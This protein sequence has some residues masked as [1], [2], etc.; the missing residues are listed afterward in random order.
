MESD[1]DA[2]DDEE[3]ILK[4]AGKIR[5]EPPHQKNNNLHMRKQRR[6]NCEAVQ[7]LCFSYTDISFCDCTGWFS[8]D[9]TG[10]PNCC[11]SHAKTHIQ[12][13]TI[14]CFFVN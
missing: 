3:D 10:T 2:D 7:H 12:V 14:P 1:Q 6:S 4:D 8:L 5:S 13:E 11:F 9:L